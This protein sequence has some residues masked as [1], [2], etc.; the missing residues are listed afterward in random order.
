M[1]DL[2]SLLTPFRTQRAGR[3]RGD[4][5]VNFHALNEAHGHLTR[6]AVLVETGAALATLDDLL[7][8]GRTRSLDRCRTLSMHFPDLNLW[9]H[10]QL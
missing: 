8:C 10:R 4:Y 2:R 1:F 6:D 9:V 7:L 5:L 3:R